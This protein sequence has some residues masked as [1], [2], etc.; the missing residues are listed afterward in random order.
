MA[1]STCPLSK[2]CLSYVW[3]GSMASEHQQTVRASLTQNSMLGTPSTS[4]AIQRKGLPDQVHCN[5]VQPSSWMLTGMSCSGKACTITFC[6]A[7]TQ[8]LK[9]VGKHPIE[10]CID[11][12]KLWQDLASHQSRL[13]QNSDHYVLFCHCKRL[14]YHALCWSF[15][16]SRFAVRMY[17][18]CLYL[19]NVSETCCVC[20]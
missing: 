2:T 5:P 4:V 15:G 10:A 14:C 20:S 17:L 12:V 1:G 13:Q 8:A 16:N 18:K 9:P 6:T 3:Q 11:H 7:D 19:D